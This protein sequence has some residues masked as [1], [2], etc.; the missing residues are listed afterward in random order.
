IDYPTTTVARKSFI[1][2]HTGRP[3]TAFQFQVYDLCS[4][5]PAG[6]VS[7]Y[8]ALADA[9]GSGS[10][11]SIG[12]A[13]KVNPFAPNPVPCHR[14]VASDFYIGG[15]QGDWGVDDEGNKVDSKRAKL[16]K[17]GVEFDGHGYV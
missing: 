6:K 7:T 15:F 8:K 1:N 10:P 5:I 12:Q 14:V 2:R 4:Q 16:K 17:E 13:L 3:V 9:L 11:R